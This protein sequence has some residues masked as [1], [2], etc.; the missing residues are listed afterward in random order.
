[1]GRFVWAAS[2]RPGWWA[3]ATKTPFGQGRPWTRAQL[4]NLLSIGL[5]QVTASSSALYMPPMATPLV[6]SG[7]EGWEVMGRLLAPGLGGVVLVEAVKRLYASPGGGATAPVTEKVRLA[8]P[9]TSNG[10]EIH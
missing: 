10:R 4:M 9:A 6:S 8:R 2:N 1:V 3:R 5:F 7:A